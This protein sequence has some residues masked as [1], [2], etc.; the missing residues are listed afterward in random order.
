M[1]AME[2]SRRK[3]Q[4]VSLAAL[5]Q[6][7]LPRGAHADTYPVRPIEMVVPYAPSGGTDFVARQ[8][9]HGMSGLLGQ[10]VLVSNKPGAATI[11]GTELVAKA[12]PDGYTL[13]MTSF[14]LAANPSLYEK[15]PYDAARE[16]APISLVTN[17]P[18]ILVASPQFPASTAQELI[19]YCKA[20]PGEV[21]YASYGIGSGAHL[22]AELFQSAAGVKLF[23]VPYEGGGPAA[24]A[25][26]RNEAQLLF[27]SAL[28]VMGSVRD[29]LLHAIG[30]AD[31]KR[32]PALPDVPT[33]RESGVDY[34]TGTWFGLL[35]P[36]GTPQPIIDR[37][38]TSV[39]STMN[40][41]VLRKQI[42]DQGA[43]PLGTQPATFAEFLRTETARWAS[44]ISRAGI[45]KQ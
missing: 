21:N 23:H 15:L 8:L 24:S 5:G 4:L 32:L 13:L 40:E 10:Q 42:A 28:P 30:V 17:A 36:A 6:A 38:A 20:H 11:V 34:A 31:G 18:T 37:I 26:M 9:A 45:A 43:Q 22:A 14:P 16:L 29:G 25:V 2:L 39:I 1:A 35:V 41:P 7:A 33:F 12:K 27:S 19:A 44:V 3:F